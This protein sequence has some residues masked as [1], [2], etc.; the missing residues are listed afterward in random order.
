MNSQEKQLRVR[1][2]RRL[3]ARSD[4]KELVTEVVTIGSETGLFLEK[5]EEKKMTRA[6]FL[7]ID[8]RGKVQGQCKRYILDDRVFHL[9]N[10]SYAIYR[11]GLADD[12]GVYTLATYEAIVNGEHTYRMMRKK[13]DT[14]VPTAPG[15]DE[16]SQAR[17]R[18]SGPS[19]VEVSGG[20]FSRTGVLY[21]PPIIPFGYHKR[22][23]EERLQYVTAIKMNT[24]GMMHDAS[25]R[26]ISV[27]GVLIGVKGFFDFEY[28]EVVEV[29]FTLLQDE[30]EAEGVELTGL[31]YVVNH[32]ERKATECLLGLRIMEESHTEAFEAY[33]LGL[34][35]RYRRKYKLDVEDEF[36]TAAAWIYERAYT[37]N[38]IPLPFFVSQDD[39]GRLQ[40]QT[41]IVADGNQPL[42]DFFKDQGGLDDYS[43]LGLPHRLQY[44]QEHGEL[45]MALY[46]VDGDKGAGLYSATSNEFESTDDWYR[47]LRY[48]L[49]RKDYRVLKMAVSSIP[50]KM[51]N[52]EKVEGI[53]ESMME[54]CEEDA[55]D[56]LSQ[57]SLLSFSAQLIDI[58]VQMKTLLEIRG[59]STRVEDMS[60]IQVWTKNVRCHVVDG[61]VSKTLSEE[62]AALF[63]ELIHF[64][65]IYARTEHRYVAEIGVDIKVDGNKITTVTKDLSVR[66]L[67]AVLPRDVS[68]KAD[69]EVSVGLP[70]LQKMCPN[71]SLS[72]IPYRLVKVVAG[73]ENRLMLE[74]VRGNHL[75][76]ELDKFFIDLIDRNKKKLKVDREDINS[77]ANIRLHE[78][79]VV[80]NLAGVPFFIARD[81]QGKAV[82][83][84]V[85]ISDKPS[86]LG[87]FFRSEDGRYDLRWITE[88][89]VVVDLFGSVIAMRGSSSSNSQR[90]THDGVEMYFYKTQGAEEG[91][92]EIHAASALEFLEDGEKERFI[93]KAIA[94]GDYL[95]VKLMVTYTMDL[96]PTELSH[97]LDPLRTYSRHK[98]FKLQGQLRSLLGCGEMF[99][100][101]GEILLT[102]GKETSGDAV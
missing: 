84:W 14:F 12:N 87:E 81:D 61:S 47:F 67:C 91:G 96:D 42:Q 22:R 46:H 35:E 33:I 93:S 55:K 95:F 34:I 76:D 57:I 23:G 18:E 28:G 17:P 3:D 58:T 16:S 13:K 88:A 4:R 49:G 11:K 19:R 2:Y 31:K 25:T 41:V 29:D 53:M 59:D 39:E 43:P 66:G 102:Y 32:I 10:I 40:T 62:D 15:E 20:E 85:A 69:S 48:A 73:R 94:S 86:S 51:P 21:S 64:G 9:D 101:S 98:V 60:G 63:P 52:A 68:L 72:D 7:T 71:A 78:S 45:I 50:L 89:R 100:I 83:Q 79:I 37:E 27:S 99:D 92:A 1:H 26:D 90:K 38:L 80:D 30:D 65:R 8:M 44:L 54:C 6:C 75:N 97:V 24:G 74:R 56:L 70:K 5:M 77:T 82:M 36:W